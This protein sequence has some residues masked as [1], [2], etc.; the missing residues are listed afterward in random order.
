MINNQNYK[1][2]A[3]G[4]FNSIVPT[5]ENMMALLEKF[6]IYEFVPSIFNEIVVDNNNLPPQN[7]QRIAL[8]SPSGNE[9]IIIGTN[10]I[11]YIINSS[12]S[13]EIEYDDITQIN[14]KVLNCFRIILEK[15]NRRASRLAINAES[16]ITEMDNITEFLDKYSNPISLY[17]SSDLREWNTRLMTRKS[18]DI[19]DESEELNVI[20]IL[21]RV[22]RKIENENEIKIEDG[23]VIHVDINTLYENGNQRFSVNEIE[24]FLTF[25]ISLLQQ[26]IKEIG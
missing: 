8:I 21:T 11:D 17:S 10:R 23:I 25:A 20:T 6:K 7:V 9:Q 22:N 5:T 12:E 15:F 13:T 26:I 1:V 18:I 16:L 3:F 14:D 4:D 19:N 2:S 24:G